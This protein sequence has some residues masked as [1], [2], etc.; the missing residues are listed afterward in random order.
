[1][2]G[3]K[4]VVQFDFGEHIEDARGGA[5][6]AEEV[7]SRFRRLRPLFKRVVVKTSTKRDLKTR[8]GI[9][10]GISEKE[11]PQEGEVIATS[12]DCD[13]CRKGDDVVYSRYAGALMQVGNENYLIIQER[14]I[15]AVYPKSGS[16]PRRF[17]RKSQVPWGLFSFG[18]LCLVIYML[19]QYLLVLAH[20]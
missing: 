2:G 8:S 13:Y 5:V 11:V 6:E 18:A 10:L 16:D 14:D 17:K 15:L 12:V 1:L 4:E 3:E 9:L 20:V 7:L 19:M